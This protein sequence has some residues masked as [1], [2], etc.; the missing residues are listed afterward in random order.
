M[1]LIALQIFE[2]FSINPTPYAWVRFICLY[3][4]LVNKVI[5]HSMRLKISFAKCTELTYLHYS[6]LPVVLIFKHLVWP[7]GHH[8]HFIHRSVPNPTIYSPQGQGSLVLT[9]E[10]SR[11]GPYCTSFV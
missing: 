6:V 11:T 10:S 5:K 7:S 9:F 4:L 1:V 3:V 8:I 2:A